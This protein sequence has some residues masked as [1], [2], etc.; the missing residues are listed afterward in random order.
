MRENETVP[1]EIRWP[2]AG[3]YQPATA[4]TSASEH[5]KPADEG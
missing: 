3:D 1:D 4:V 5:D 2:E